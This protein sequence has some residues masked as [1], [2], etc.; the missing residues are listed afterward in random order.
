MRRDCSS[1]AP[2]FFEHRV[3]T[4]SRT[5]SRISFRLH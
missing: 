5:I 1:I 2:R 3:C 4:K